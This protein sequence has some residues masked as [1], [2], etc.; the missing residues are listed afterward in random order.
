MAA[1]LNSFKQTWSSIVKAFTGCGGKTSEAPT[2]TTVEISEGVGGETTITTL[3]T[4]LI[5]E[6]GGG[7]THTDLLVS[8]LKTSSATGEQDILATS[9]ISSGGGGSNHDTAL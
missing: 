9:L 3:D 2:T 8:E 1:L 7:S 5:S 6:G 4:L